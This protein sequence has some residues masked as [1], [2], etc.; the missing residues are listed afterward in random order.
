MKKMILSALLLLAL[1]SAMAL[2]DDG[3]AVAFEQLP[4]KAQQFIKEHFGGHKILY[5][6]QDTDWFE[7]D[8]EVLFEGGDKVAF[9]RNGE[10]EDVECKKSQVPASIVPAAVGDYVGKK[11][12]DTR[13]VEI[14]RNTRGY[15]VKL[16]DG[17]EIEFDRKGKMLRYDL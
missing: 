4:E 11:H 15:E 1:G 2:T 9:R 17:V 8:Y 3:R 12:P 16:S 14:E 7:G 13:I 10:W 6:E 5:A